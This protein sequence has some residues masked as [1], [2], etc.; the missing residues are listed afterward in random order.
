[1]NK[2]NFRTLDVTELS[3]INGGVTI[4][5]GNDVVDRVLQWLLDTFRP[6]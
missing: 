2:S 3:E 6:W 5:T 4:P 1:M